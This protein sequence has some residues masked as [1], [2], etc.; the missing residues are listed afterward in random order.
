VVMPYGPDD[1]GEVGHLGLGQS[2]RRLVEEQEPR[3]RGECPGDAELALV[4]MREAG[5]R[6]SP[7]A[8]QPEE[9]EQPGGAPARL[10][11][12]RART[13]RG[14]LDVLTHRQAAERAAGLKR[15]RGPAAAAAVRAPR[16]DVT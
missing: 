13:E 11:G 15:A 8:V 14:H 10:A 4:T 3:L 5:C 16:R 6:L 12:P 1:R 7:A 9:L 2:G